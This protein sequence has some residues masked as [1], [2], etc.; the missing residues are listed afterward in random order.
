MQ[1]FLPLPD[2]EQS[3]RCLDRQR[4]GKQ[5][6]E[7][8]Q[9]L[10]ALTVPGSGWARH[11]AVG[12]WDG[13]VTHLLQYMQVVIDEWT[14]RGY[15]NNM[16]VPHMLDHAD[17]APAWLG[18]EG[19]HRSHRSNLLRKDPVHYG[20]FGWTE[21]SD[22]PYIWPFREKTTM[23]AKTLDELQVLHS[24][25][26]ATA[27][28]LGLPLPKNLTVDF[29]DEV[30]GTKITKEIDRMIGAFRE[31]HEKK[32]QAGAKTGKL[33]PPLPKEASSV[34]KPDDQKPDADKPL[35]NGSAEGHTAPA[36]RDRVPGHET[37]E[38]MAQQRAARLAARKPS[39]KPTRAEKMAKAVNGSMGLTA[40][41]E[42]KVKAPK[43]AKK[44]AKKPAKKAA[45]KTAKKTGERKPRAA[46]YPEGA[47]ITALVKEN[48]ARKG[49][50]RHGR[51]Q[52][53]IDHGGKTVEAFVKAKGKL[54]TLRRCV[55]LKIAKVA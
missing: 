3:A 48:P 25:M 55:E 39:N 40:E 43:K 44:A 54:A 50:A 7:C 9:I 51:V 16:I 36:S 17:P 2:F 5:R 18:D 30:Q 38:L 20:Q 42:K 53:V 37:D 19:F 29:T 33:P 47:K 14:R 11:P 1:T 49:T 35:A 34:Q 13:Y 23:T 6:L 41:G 32:E 8:K 46:A 12:M 27:H 45:K 28:D 10:M 15:Q 21:P 52:K 26:C 4:L 24:E 31:M 22:L